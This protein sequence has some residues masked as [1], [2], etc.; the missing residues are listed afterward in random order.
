MKLKLLSLATC[1]LMGLSS[2]AFAQGACGRALMMAGPDI[3]GPAEVVQKRMLERECELERADDRAR[4]QLAQRRIE[5]RSSWN[6][7]RPEIKA[8]INAKLE[9]DGRTIDQLINLGISA[10]DEGIAPYRRECF[11]LPAQRDG[12]N[13]G[14]PSFTPPPAAAANSAGAANADRNAPGA[15][16]STLL[17]PTGRDS[18]LA[19]LPVQ[20]DGGRVVIAPGSNTIVVVPAG[21]GGAQGTRNLSLLEA[22]VNPLSG[23]RRLWEAFKDEGGLASFSDF[24]GVKINKAS[25]DVERDQV[26]TSRLQ[27]PAATPPRKVREA[28]NEAC[29]G[30]EQDWKTATDS[31][32]TRGEL[33]TPQLICRYETDDGA[34]DYEVV[35]QKRK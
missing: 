8:C 9:L 34:S 3:N 35:M 21:R 26:T 28:L 33:L 6:A 12:A 16:G 18:G 2:S 25:V 20:S 24:H 4:Q 32:G 15:S 13:T 27:V 14:A 19:D 31:R 17:S 11:G 1:A 10:S 5:A 7:V 23:S 22:A 30:R 29:R